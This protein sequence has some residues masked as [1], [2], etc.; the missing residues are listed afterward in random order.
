M[1]KA[2]IID[3]EEDARFMLRSLIERHFADKVEIAGEADSVSGGIEMINRHKPELVFLDIRMNRETG[4]DLLKA[5]DNK[6]FE[7]VFVTAYDEYAVNA[8]RFSAMGYLMKPVKISALREVI[9]SLVKKSTEDRNDARKRLKILIE[10][11]GS[12]RKISKLVISNMEGFRV[13]DIEE[14]IRL[15]GDR[16]YTNFILRDGKRILATKTLGDYEQLLNEFG[17]FRIHQSTVVNLRHVTAF[18]RSDN[19]VEMVDGTQHAVSR[20]RKAA[21]LE[22]FI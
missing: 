20:L 19:M 1:I 9:E 15:E 12:D 14:I 16:N 21:F 18:H 5:I 11:Y 17:F 4:F 7:V 3:D 6:D 13:V 2:I 22:R 10:N 8:F